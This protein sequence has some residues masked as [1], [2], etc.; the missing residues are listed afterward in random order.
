MH[1]GP[2]KSLFLRLA[3]SSSISVAEPPSRRAISVLVANFSSTNVTSGSVSGLRRHHHDEESRGVRVSVWWDLEKCQFPADTN[4]FKV[5]QT[6]TSAVRFNG[7]KGP[8]TITA[9]GDLLQLSRTNQEA[10]FATGISFTHVPQGE[11][12]SVDRS[13]I[14]DLMCWVTQNPP[15]AHIFLISSNRD[16]ASLLHRLRMK[17]YNILL[18]CNEEATSGVLCSAASIMWDW[19][20]LVRGE[21]YTGKHFN[22]PPDGPYNSWY[23]HYKTP[24]LDPFATSC[25]SVKTEELRESNSNPYSGSSKVC[26]PIPKE[27][28][29]QIGLILSLYPKGASI[30]QLREQLSKRNV[31]L[32]K[33][34][35][36]H[37]SFFR[38]LLSMP[39][40]LQVVLAGDGMFLVH[41]RTQEMDNKAS[42]PKLSSENP[43]AASV[44]K[45]HQKVKQ[46]VEDVKEESQSQESSHES[47]PVISQMDVKAKDEPV[48][49]NQLA[50]TSGDDVSSSKGKDGFFKKLNRLWFGSPE[51]ELDHRQGKKSI[52]GNGDE[53]KGIVN[54]DT[55]IGNGKSATPGILS[56]VLK[57][58]EFIWGTN[59]ELRNA[60]AAETQVGDIFAK[61]SFWKDVESFI[62]SPRGF[63]VVSHSISRDVL[64]KN[65][66]DEGPSSLKPLDVSKMLDLVS[67][68]VSEKKWIKENSSDAL[69]FRVTRFTEKG[70]GLDH[71]CASSGLRSIFTSMSKSQCDEADD[72]KKPKNIGISKKPLERSRREVIEDCHKLIK[73]ITEENPGG[74][75]MSN[76]KKDFLE[77]FGYRLDY[78]SLG[79]PKLQSLIQ[80]MPE[81]RIESGYIVPS[82]TPA[83][84]DSTSSFEELG[85]RKKVWTQRLTKR[86]L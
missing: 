50:I 76:L 78:R 52:S 65:L 36:G 58:F 63:V 21:N 17:N 85:P 23:G 47:V 12:N 45:M 59:S 86:L 4:V 46:N 54:A 35:Y 25:T 77:K 79:Y 2:S 34:F 40:V 33:D 48:K 30:T 5:S 1:M 37:K 27:V 31:P 53:W 14:T 51:M 8:I 64:A 6:I 74:Y 68:L 44:E 20:G 13:L 3:R 26:G 80:M 39:K 66:K 75:N 60:A 55:V 69:P 61:D 38:F 29:K 70:S 24:L 18:A 41:A 62:N 7:I 56:R 72:E 82:S 22:Q 43:K 81:A 9:F 83:P 15:P 32:D 19:N 67:L 71:S 28:V 11:E 42:L 49:E 57:R 10:L 16:L 73:K 84:Y